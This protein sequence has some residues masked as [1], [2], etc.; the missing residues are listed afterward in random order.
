M[1]YRGTIC[2]LTEK[3]PFCTVCLAVFWSVCSS[4]IH[5][6]AHSGLSVGSQ[7][8]SFYP[9]VWFVFHVAARLCVPVRDFVCLSVHLSVVLSVRLL[10]CLFFCR[11]VCSSVGL[12]VCPTV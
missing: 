8:L 3:T 12:S 11:S 2:G 4:V 7:F 5:Y 10:V 1:V 6:P 9:R